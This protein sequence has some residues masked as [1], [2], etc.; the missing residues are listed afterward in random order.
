MHYFERALMHIPTARGRSSPSLRRDLARLFYFFAIA[1]RQVG[2]RNRSVASLVEASRLY[3][4]GCARSGLFH[5]V[6]RYGMARQPTPEH[7]DQQAFYG[8]QLSHYVRSKQ[9][10]RLGT[11]AEIDMVSELIDEYWAEIKRLDL[12]S[13]SSVDK[14]RLFSDTMIVF[15]FITVPNALKTDD[16]IVDF[17]SGRRADSHDRCTCGSGLPV[18]LCHGRIPG[19][20]EVLV[21]LF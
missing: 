9:S 18:Y 3:K 7:D 16:L 13:M 17:R 1:L 8:I 20:D 12:A 21:G 19:I 2:L 15:P 14:C 5:A 11:R 6:N 10:H 4:R